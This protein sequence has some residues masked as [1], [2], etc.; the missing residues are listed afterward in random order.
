MTMRRNARLIQKDC[1]NVFPKLF[2][3]ETTDEPGIH[4]RTEA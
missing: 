4:L 3:H 1:M 2:Q